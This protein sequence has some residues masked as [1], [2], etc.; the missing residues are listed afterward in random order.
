MAT[1]SRSLRPSVDF[2][3]QTDNNNEHPHTNSGNRFAVLGDLP[4]QNIQNIKPSL[5]TLT[6]QF[7]SLQ[8]HNSAS[9]ENGFVQPQ[10]SRNHQERRVRLSLDR[11]TEHSACEN[12]RVSSSSSSGIFSRKSTSESKTNALALASHHLPSN[13]EQLT[14]HQEGQFEW[15]LSLP[16]RF[17]KS[18]AAKG[19]RSL[20]GSHDDDDQ[21]SQGE[22]QLLFGCN[23]V[24]QRTQPGKGNDK[25][26]NTYTLLATRIEQEE[27]SIFEEPEGLEDT[28]SIIANTS[29]D[30]LTTTHKMWGSDEVDDLKKL[31][32]TLASMN[33]QNGE[34]N[35]NFNVVEQ[36]PH[37]ERHTDQQ[38][39]LSVSPQHS[40]AHSRPLSRIEDSVEELDKLQEQLE[41]LEEVAQLERVISPEMMEVEEEEPTEI[42]NEFPPAPSP[43]PSPKQAPAVKRASSVRNT[44]PGTSSSLRS[45][46]SATTAERSSVRK[47][48]ASSSDDKSTNPMVAIRRSTVPRPTSL[49][50]PKAPTKSSKTP[51]VPAF[52]LPGEAVARRLK[53][54][55]AARL[56]QSLENQVPM[57]PAHHT[58]TTS[59]SKVLVAPTVRSTKPLTRPQFEL[60]GEAISRRKREERE[61]KLR[62]QEEEEK[63]RREFRARPVPTSVGIKAGGGGGV[64]RETVASS[65][66]KAEISPLRAK[67]QS[68]VLTK[69]ASSMGP[70]RGRMSTVGVVG[71]GENGRTGEA[72]GGGS[73]RATSSSSSSSSSSSAGVA[74][75]VGN[76]KGKEVF[77][78]DGEFA[79]EREREKRERE[80]A[81]KMARKE[82]AE[83]SR[84]A[85]REWR[86]RRE[87]MVRERKRMSM[88]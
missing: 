5:D 29:H 40:P 33:V 9:K 21:R 81:A 17:A 71:V 39:H 60:P 61:A 62:Q 83:R 48:V 26:V 52:E 4:L 22:K 44:F 72:S 59:P 66:R 84:E 13:R 8:I 82:A 75:K 76:L 46:T 38:R 31:S 56:S 35:N 41:A 18:A 85:G 65:A 19:R 67:R 20:S 47:S 50:P 68:L 45:R 74:G 79:A 28:Q 14:K 55:R 12:S 2:D 73:S 34:G 42:I 49:L 88:V 24:H 80:E 53:E 3:I 25:P 70:I 57:K 7:S 37:W 51:T 1:T 15:L 6:R 36:Q 63:R 32:E 10:V 27:D 23:L 77:K 54:Q 86:E 30:S 11:N 64:S 87:M 78:R 58:S 69:S 16:I 43:A